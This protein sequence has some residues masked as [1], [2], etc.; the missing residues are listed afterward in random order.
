MAVPVPRA[1]FC[2]AT[3][4]GHVPATLMV[5]V[6]VGEAL[7]VKIALWVAGAMVAW[8]DILVEL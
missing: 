5:T 1:C 4:A 8:M 2:V 3:E 7:E 6:L